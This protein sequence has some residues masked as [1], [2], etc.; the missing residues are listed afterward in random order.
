MLLFLKDKSIGIK[1][2]LVV[3]INNYLKSNKNKLFIQL[4]G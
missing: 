2:A 1:T 4:V 3:F